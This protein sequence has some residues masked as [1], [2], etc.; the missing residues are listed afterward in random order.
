MAFHKIGIKKK[1]KAGNGIENDRNGGDGILDQVAGENVLS[2]ELI[3][4]Q[5]R[6]G[7]FPMMEQMSGP[8]TGKSLR[9]WGKTED[10]ERGERGGENAGGGGQGAGCGGRG[11]RGVR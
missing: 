7:A 3:C 2:E 8:E 1:S 4:E 9:S 6:G 5:R 11:S 10:C